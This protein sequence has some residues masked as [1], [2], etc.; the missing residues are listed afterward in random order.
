MEKIVKENHDQVIAEK[1]VSVIVGFCSWVFVLALIIF[2]FITSFASDLGFGV[3]FFYFVL[4]ILDMVLL[5]FYF[6]GLLLPRYLIIKRKNSLIIKGKKVLMSDV[7]G[8]INRRPLFM[9]PARLYGYGNIIFMLKSGRK[10]TVHHVAN[11]DGVESAL[12]KF[13][14]GKSNMNQ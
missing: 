4:L 10:I 1:S 8:I 7:N 12:S 11:V 9:V 6:K 5:I 14:Y 2:G 3:R 13:I